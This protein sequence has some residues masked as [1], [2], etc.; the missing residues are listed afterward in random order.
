MYSPILTN[1][2]ASLGALLAHLVK[3]LRVA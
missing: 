3:S 2:D 1:I